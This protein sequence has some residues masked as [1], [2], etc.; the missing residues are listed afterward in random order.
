MGL[1]FDRSL[2]EGAD[3]EPVLLVDLFEL[4]DSLFERVNFFSVFDVDLFFVVDWFFN[5][6]YFFLDLDGL[7]DSLFDDEFV[8]FS[9][10][11]SILAELLLELL[12]VFI[13]GGGCSGCLVGSL[14]SR[15]LGNDDLS[16][17]LCG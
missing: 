17:R 5:L 3:L 11:G 2:S 16:G 10:N 1:D 4:D 12:G 14:G 8:S 9:D 6:N 15:L 13:G 7:G